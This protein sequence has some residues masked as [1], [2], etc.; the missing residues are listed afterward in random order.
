MGLLLWWRSLPHRAQ[1][2]SDLSVVVAGVVVAFVV[3][4]VDVVGV[5]IGFVVV[6]G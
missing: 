2:G 1:I 5:A 4:A 3:I 6:G